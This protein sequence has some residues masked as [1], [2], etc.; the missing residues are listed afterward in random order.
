VDHLERDPLL[1]SHL[2]QTPLYVLLAP[3]DAGHA[4]ALPFVHEMERKLDGHLGS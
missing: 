4:A 3:A 1:E 2:R